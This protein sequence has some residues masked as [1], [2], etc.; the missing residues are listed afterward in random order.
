MSEEK[1]KQS[2]MARWREPNLTVHRYK[3]SGPD[4]SLIS[5]HA[6]AHLSVRLVPGQEVDEVAQQLS[7]FLEKEF[8]GLKSQNWLRVNVDNMA[9][10]WLGDPTNHIFQTLEQAIVEAHSQ[11][12]RHVASAHGVLFRR[13]A[14]CYRRQPLHSFP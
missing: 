9:E 3:V 12:G 4:G 11:V 1:L 13:V 8:A 14:A 5:S 6:S 2:L 7:E 10:P